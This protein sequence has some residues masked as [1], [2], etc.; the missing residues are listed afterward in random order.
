VIG[1]TPC[2]CVVKDD[3]TYNVCTYMRDGFMQA[4]AVCHMCKRH[5]NGVYLLSAHDGAMSRTR[6]LKG[7]MQGTLQRRIK[8][9]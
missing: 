3:T 9:K 8:K 6:Q 1:N 2:S 4:E 5:W 7:T